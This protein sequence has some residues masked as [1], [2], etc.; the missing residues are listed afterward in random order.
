MRLS[1]SARLLVGIGILVV[2]LVGQGTL[3]VILMDRDRVA[4]AEIA[5]SKVPVLEA[6]YRMELQVRLQTSLLAAYG[7]HP[8][9]DV[10]TEIESTRNQYR[11]A[12]IAYEL[13]EDK[14]QV[15]W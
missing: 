4:T 9:P 5:S 7:N 3:S 13:F 1:L 8:D 12:L 6:V 11:A 15:A 2:L 10:G 14:K